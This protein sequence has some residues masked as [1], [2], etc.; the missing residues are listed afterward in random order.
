MKILKITFFALAALFATN[1]FASGESKES[2]MFAE[3][4]TTRGII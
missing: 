2:K 3:I 1:V 4:T